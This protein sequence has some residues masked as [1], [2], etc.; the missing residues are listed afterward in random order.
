MFRVLQLPNDQ[1]FVVWVMSRE[2]KFC[3]TL[4][5]FYSCLTL[6]AFLE[7][8]FNFKYKLLHKVKEYSF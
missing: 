5:L 2:L 7:S 1:S 4:A 6:L 8:K 3:Q